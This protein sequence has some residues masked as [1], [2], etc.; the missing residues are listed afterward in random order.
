MANPIEA[1]EIFTKCDLKAG[2]EEGMGSHTEYIEKAIKDERYE[3][4]AAMKRAYDKMNIDF[5][6]NE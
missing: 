3:E 6:S 2:R 4:V 5:P 1:I